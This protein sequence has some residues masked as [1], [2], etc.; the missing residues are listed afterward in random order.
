M[1]HVVKTEPLV[2][3]VADDETMA[4]HRLVR[5][6]SAMD[7]ITIAG[8]CEDG[9]AALAFLQ[10]EDV[11]LAVLDIQ[12]PG[13]TGL[14]VKALL[15]EGGPAVIF[16]TAHAEHS[17][18]AFEVGALDYVLKPVDPERLEKAVSRVQRRLAG[19]A[20]A[21]DL[22]QPLALA[23]KGAIHLVAPEEISHATFD[24]QLVTLHYAGKTLLSDV[25][26]SEL[27]ARLPTPPFERVH[28]R[29]LVNLHAV[30]QLEPN[31]RGGYHAQL[32]GGG[33]VEVARQAARRLRRQLGI[34]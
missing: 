24:G 13:L 4:R 26:L 31:G 22:G 10:R 30:S 12:M 1:I 23:S 6:L 7:G 19:E 8:Q 28:R 16:V 34:R 15:E 11:D 32:R 17:L 9:L 2:V 14:D 27:D 21:A 5:L 18:A 25:S 33:S 20:A 3:L 29:A